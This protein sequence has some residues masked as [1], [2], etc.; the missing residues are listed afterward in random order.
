[1]RGEKT[2]K[3]VILNAKG[4]TQFDV[5]ESAAYGIICQNLDKG[6]FAFCEPDKI[7]VSERSD[8]DAIEVEKAIIFAPVAGGCC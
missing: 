5:G 3:I 1:V 8:L 7:V 2:V 6:M 4:H